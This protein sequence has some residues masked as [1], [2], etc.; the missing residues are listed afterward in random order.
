MVRTPERVLAG[1][2]LAKQDAKTPKVH[3]RTVATLQ[4]HL[5]RH[6]LLRAAERVGNDVRRVLCLRDDDAAV[7]HAGDDS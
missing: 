7:G 5:W 2:H 6:V 3:R 4:Q 1:Q